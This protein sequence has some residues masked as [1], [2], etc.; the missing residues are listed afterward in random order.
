V[1][2]RLDHLGIVAGVCQEIGLAAWLDAQDGRLHERVSVGTATVAMILNGLGFS[3]RQLYLVPQFFADK[4]VETLL[5]P[6]ITAAD[7]NDDC[8][9]RTLDWLYAHDPT[10]LFA[11]IAAQARRVFGIQARQ[12]HVDTTSF[13]VSG[14]YVREEGDLDAT[15]IAITYGYSRDHRAD[16]KQWMLALATTHEGDVPVFLRPLSGNSSDQVSLLAAVEALHDQLQ[17]PEAA[18]EAMYVAD[19]AIY[20]VANMTR[21]NVLGI[22][23]ISRVPGTSIEAKTALSRTDVAWQRSADGKTSWWSQT[24]TLPQGEERWMIVRTQAGEAQAR[25]KVQRAVEKAQ[26]E[27]TQRIWHLSHQEFACEADARA[28]LEREQKELPTWLEIQGQ[29]V[30]QPRYATKG[31]PRKEVAPVAS[32]WHLQAQVSVNQ[33]RVEQEVQRQACFIV[34]TNRLDP[35]RLS[36]EELVATYKD[37]GGVERGF[38]FLKDPL[39]LASSV[40][41]K[42]PERIMA[43]SLIMVLC[44]LV[45]RLAE[46]R[47]RTRL[48]ETGQTIPDQLAKPTVRPTMRWVFQCFEGIELLHVLTA[49]MRTTLV[50]RLQPLH[51]QILALLGPPYQH[52]YGGAR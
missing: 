29:V 6:G 7:L 5:G 19:G 9:G 18:E 35:T 41:V 47:L 24:L 32:V 4:P 40:F 34:G 25:A 51:E 30:A 11:G 36:A 43:L 13:S 48:V 10:T 46:H 8:L 20:S 21:L 44:L 52:F 23:W 33:D 16:L 17:A 2:E 28:A 37:Q 14:A 38:R 42:K 22:A 26:R 45:Y 3:N 1:N 49:G 12:V 27:W 50:L 31:R 39:F 15:T